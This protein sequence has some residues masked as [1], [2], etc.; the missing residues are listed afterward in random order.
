MGWWSPTILGGDE[1]LDDVLAFAREFGGYDDEQWDDWD[2]E[3]ELMR[4][5]LAR[6]SES[7]VLTFIDNRDS[8]SVAQVVALAYMS[9]GAILP[10]SIRERAICACSSE[11]VSGWSEPSVRR[12]HLNELQLMVQNYDDRTPQVPPEE[13]LF[14]VVEQRM[15]SGSTGL[16]NDNVRSREVAIAA[17]SSGAEKATTV[18]NSLARRLKL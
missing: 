13:G 18:W 7:D 16:I 8:A 5:S 4:Q 12:A 11:D 1:P 10:V 15:S 3:P 2:S 9:C 6:S 14:D 17:G